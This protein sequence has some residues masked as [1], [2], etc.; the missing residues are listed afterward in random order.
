MDVHVRTWEEDG[1]VGTR[2]FG[3]SFMGHA[4]AEDMIAHFEKCTDSL[5]ISKLAQ[6][7]MDEPNVNWRFHRLL[8]DKIQNTFQNTLIDIGSCGLHI[9][10]NAYKDGAA[11]TGWHVD[12][13]LSS[14]YYLIKDTPA[15]REDFRSVTSSGLFPLKFCGHR[16][17]ENVPVAERALRIMPAVKTYVDNV[18][19]EVGEESQH[20]IF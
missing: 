17:L 9:I 1:K 8:Q 12:K 15:R 18:K 7:S 5:S 20:G 2:Y 14:L 3:S 10:H 11:A 19:D 4:C 6:V 13:F 16:W